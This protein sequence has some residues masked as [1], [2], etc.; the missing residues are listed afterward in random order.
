MRMTLSL[1]IILIESTNN[2]TYGL[3]LMIT[4]MVA[5]WVGDCF[6]SGIY[7]IYIGLRNI[8]YLEWEPEEEMKVRHKKYLA[9]S[10]KMSSMTLLISFFK[11][12]VPLVDLQCPTCDD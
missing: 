1:T 9:S 11:L 2:I 5:K 8:P 4:L 10:L 12:I 3:P 7:D 6:T